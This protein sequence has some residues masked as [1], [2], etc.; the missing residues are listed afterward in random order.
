[1][2]KLAQI[3]WQKIIID[4]LPFWITALIVVAAAVVTYRSNRK[5]VESQNELGRKSRLADHQNK[6]SEFRHGWLQD[7]RNTSA[8]LVKILHE[9]RISMILKDREFG[10]AGQTSVSAE[11]ASHLRNCEAFEAQFLAAR[12][13]FY[14]SHS[15]LKLLFKPNDADANQLLELLDEARTNLFKEPLLVDDEFIDRIVS[16][17]QVILKTEWEV[18][19]NRTWLEST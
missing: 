1:M 16:E 3:D 9:C 6:I 17:L 19:K 2:S 15:K 7:L 18:T 12:S 4:G 14:K 5:S 10:W 11:S 13:E 8:D